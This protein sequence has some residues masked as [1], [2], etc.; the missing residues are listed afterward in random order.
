M[1]FIHS[2]TR[3]D[4]ADHVEAGRNHLIVAED[5][6]D[7]ADLRMHVA[8]PDQAVALDAVPEESCMLRWTV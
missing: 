2:V 8:E 1:P 4:V 7:H 6:V 5:A 3:G